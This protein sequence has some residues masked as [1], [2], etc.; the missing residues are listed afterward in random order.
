MRC[1]PVCAVLLLMLPMLSARL[2]AA[3]VAAVWE[4]DLFVGRDFHYTNGAILCWARNDL[5]HFEESQATWPMRWLGNLLGFRSRG[6]TFRAVSLSLRQMMQ[7]PENLFRVP[8][9]RRDVPYAGSLFWEG[10]L[11]AGNASITDRVSLL[12]GVVGPSSGAAA[13]QRWAHHAFDGIP[14]Q[15]WRFQLHNQPVINLQVRRQWRVW[16][17]Q[18]LDL[19]PGVE[20]NAGLMQSDVSA[21]VLLRFG[22]Q[23]AISFPGADLIASRTV[24]IHE[25]S[26]SGYWYAYVGLAGDLMANDLL[27]EGNEFT[28]SPGLPLKRTN[29]TRSVGLV[30]GRGPLSLAFSLVDQ[31]PKSVELLHGDRFGSISAAWRY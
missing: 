29:V 30:W 1:K 3:T 18:Y 14:P 11:Y 25:P 2:E 23:L 21:G 13:T 16:N 24:A 4:N 27:V 19:V 12:V 17:N 22:Q 31:S 28:D 7:T 6:Y 8:P 26:A 15:G 10:R 9:N 5:R 20:V